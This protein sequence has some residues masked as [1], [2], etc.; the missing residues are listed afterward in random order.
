MKPCDD[1]WRDQLVDHVLGSPA[2]AA[3]TEHLE[4]CALCSAALL[5]WKARMGQIDGGIRQL[6]ASE[7]AAQAVSRVMAEVRARPRRRWL[8]EWKAVT[9]ALAGLIVALACLAYVWRTRERRKETQRALSAAATIESW[10]SPTQGLL[11]S[12]IDRWLKAPP[13]L[14]EYFYPLNTDV[15]EKERENR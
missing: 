10:R 15:P 1:R 12:P 6:A 8:P 11:R 13:R 9:A 7:P 3:L 2:G 4:K 14:G 5:E